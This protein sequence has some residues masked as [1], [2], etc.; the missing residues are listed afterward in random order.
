MK[1]EL[2]KDYIQDKYVIIAPGRGRR[3]HDVGV[4]QKI[5]R[6]ANPEDSVFHPKNVAK[7]K[8]LYVL[9][10][11]KDW[12]IKVI[13]NKFPAI[14]PGN[15]KAYGSQ[16]IIIETPDPNLEME[17]MSAGHISAILK[18]YA[19]RTEAVQKIKNIQYIIIFKNDGGKA[20]A[21]VSHAHSQIFATDFIPPSLLDKSHKILAYRLRTGREPYCDIIT[22]EMRGPRRVWQDKYTACF[23][24]Y[25]SMH[26]YECWIMPKRH[27]DNIAQLAEAEFKSFAKILKHIVA[28]ISSMGLA[29]NYY[30]HQIVYDENQHLYIKI[31]PRASFWAGVEIG[32]GIMINPIAPEEA[33]RY[34][35][36]GVGK[37]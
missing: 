22:K 12:K 10:G 9:G 7:I 31:T 33:A 11:E 18:V 4:A 24:P 8:G 1:S 16:E 3:P 30:F 26:N 17:D 23:T 6:Y 13:P 37:I 29:Y 25:A 5:Q 32:S 34:Y 20:G 36:E 15:P 35:R 27:V 14:T 2:R 19:R 28:K 21:S